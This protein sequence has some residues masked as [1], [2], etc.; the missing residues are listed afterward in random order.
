MGRRHSIRSV[1]AAMVLAFALSP[2]LP[3][4]G[5]IAPAN[6]AA[7]NGTKSA[8]YADAHWNDCKNARSYPPGYGQPIFS[9]DGFLCFGVPAGNDNC[10]AYASEAL[11]YGGYSWVRNLQYINDAWYWN[12]GNEGLR[13][14]TTPNDSISFRNAPD[15][16][17][18]LITYDHDNHNGGGAGGGTLKRTDYGYG[19]YNTYNDLGVGDLLFFDFGQGS[20]I[21]HVRMEI[22]WYSTQPSYSGFL[23]AWN[24]WVYRG[25]FADNQSPGRYHDFWNGFYA[26]KDGNVDPNYVTIYEVGID[27]LNV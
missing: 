19:P 5:L 3:A 20:G 8:T 14:T 1:G 15:L 2:I 13:K 23:Q 26:N 11:N 24:S 21:D 27:T 6:V 25:D 10:A 17:N 22:G 4:T 9:T 7:W 16:Y 18:F 12:L